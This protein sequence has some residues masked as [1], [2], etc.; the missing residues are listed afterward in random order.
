MEATATHI[1]RHGYA[2]MV[3]ERVASDAG[4]TRGALY[5]VF[6]NKTELTLAAVEWAYGAW[7]DDVGYLFVGGAGD[8]PVETLIAV[9][10]GSAVYTRRGDVARI[11]S[12]L[13]ADFEGVDHPVGRMVRKIAAHVL[14]DTTRLITAGQK[15]GVIPSGE[16]PRELA[17]AFHATIAGVLRAFAGQRP[18]DMLFAE[19]AALG[20][21]A[22]PPTSE[23]GNA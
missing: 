12:R 9:A 20:V 11:C 16:P 13:I 18:Y 17:L 6:A 21:L 14:D 1:A 4:C 22:L 2:E 3:L 15:A 8:D 23:T 19:R 7:R 10:R 5:H